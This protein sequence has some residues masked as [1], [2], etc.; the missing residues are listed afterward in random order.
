MRQEWREFVTLPKITSQISIAPDLSN[1]AVLEEKLL[2]VGLQIYNMN[3]GRPLPVNVHRP[4]P[5]I[6]NPQSQFLWPTLEYASDGSRI[7]YAA[8]EEDIF[9]WK[10][11]RDRESN[12]TRLEYLHST[13]C[14]PG[15]F[16]WDPS[17]GYQV[18]DDGWILSSSRKR[19]LWLPPH[20]QG[21]KKV[22]RWSG[23][24]LA[25]LHGDLPEAVILEIEV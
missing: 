2:G 19:L 17:H 20:W 23:N 10:I 9:Q 8:S 15:G 11:V 21:D 7:W 12:I 3:T 5:P 24:F 1:I 16:L 13:E 22:R 6:H 18:M 25:L 4:Y 14:P